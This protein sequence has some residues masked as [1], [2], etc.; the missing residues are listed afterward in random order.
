MW[1]PDRSGARIGPFWF[2]PGWTRGN[3]ATVWLASFFSIGLAAYMSFVQ[4]FLLNEVLKVP[5]EQQGTL[6]GT[7]G[8]LQE[9][10]I[11]GLAGFI[12]TW[13]D[14]AGRRRVYCLGFIAM[15]AGYLVYPFA[16][17]VADLYIYRI[18][19]ALGVAVVPLM[20]SAC[21]VDAIQEPCRGKWIGSNNLLQGFG[22]VAMSL[23][24]AKTPAWYLGMGADTVHAARYAYWTAAGIALFA[25]VLMGIGLPKK[26]AVQTGEQKPAMLAQM[27]AA[28][29]VGMHNPRLAVAYGAAFIGR[30][31]FVVI[32]AFFSLWI[33]QTGI[34]SGMSAGDSLARG[35]MLF[36]IVQIAAMVWAFFMGMITDRLNRV[37]ALS[38]ALGIAGIGY[39]LLG[40]V[41]DPFARSFIPIAVLVGMGEVS[42]IV[43]AGALLGQEA[44]IDL[45]GSIVGFYSAVGGVGI[46]FAT[47]VGGIVFDKIG[48]TAPFTLM[49]LLNIALLITALIVRV[50]AG[51]PDPQATGSKSDKVIQQD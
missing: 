36:G 14:R 39:L 8:L 23:L 29:Q 12:G 4:P 10:V 20:L 33:M 37:T 22:V 50:R 28:L 42:V 15:A 18:A 48:R 6:T 21:V 19:F 44:R 32:G 24:L 27:Y 46:L 45:R 31:D 25:A 41:A 2:M 51:M 1:I 9:L 34:D 13:S 7:L 26:I 30:G 11:I 49:G 17:S 43:T 35:G 40:N 47:G 5:Q 16:S 3:A 38:I